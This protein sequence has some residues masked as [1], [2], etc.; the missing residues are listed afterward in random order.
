MRVVKV[1]SIRTLLA[2]PSPTSPLFLRQTCKVGAITPFYRWEKD[3]QDL[4]VGACACRD[5]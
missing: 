1:A 3:A 4:S 5:P 2:R